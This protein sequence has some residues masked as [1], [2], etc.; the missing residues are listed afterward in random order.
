MFA[1]F[2][3][4]YIFLEANTLETSYFFLIEN[5]VSLNQASFIYFFT[6]YF[7]HFNDLSFFLSSLCFLQLRF[8]WMYCNSNSETHSIVI[9][10]RAVMY[11]K[12][13]GVSHC[14]FFQQISW[15]I[16]SPLSI[17]LFQFHL[18]GKRKPIISW[19]TYELKSHMALSG[20]GSQAIQI[21]CLENVCESIRE[22]LFTLELKIKLQLAADVFLVFLFRYFSS[23]G[24]LLS[25]FSLLK[26]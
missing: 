16:N 17:L 12:T 11:K 23:D 8:L 15:T 19:S 7:L 10:L 14:P 2:I 4:R 21:L 13:T 22:I 3:K 20:K 9:F 5:L 6:S 24:F 1:I 25:N 18:W 26:F